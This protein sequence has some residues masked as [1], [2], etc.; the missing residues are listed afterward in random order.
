MKSFKNK[1]AAITGAGSGIGRALAQALARDGAELAISDIHAARVEETAALLRA[2]GARVSA[3]V[4]D[5]SKREEVY[6]WAERVVRDH[7]KVHLIFNNA[8]VGHASTLEG[9]SIEDFEWIMGINFWGVV[10]GTKAFLPHLRAAGEGHIINL[11]SIFGVIAV[12]GNGT[13]NA[14]KFAVRGFTEALREELDMTGGAVSATCVHPGGIKTNIVREARFDESINGLLVRDAEAGKAQFEASFMTTPE[15]AARV[16]LDAVRKNKRR[17]LI[18]PDAHAFDL[19]QRVLPS[20]YQAL[21]VRAVRRM[22][23]H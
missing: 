18:G 19:M 20:A 2:Q 8:G 22:A 13:Y 1:V 4:V 10:Y 9:T 16:I 5:V 14:S 21:A 6:A 11:S 17:A 12:P 3:Q 15:K 23:P 7:G